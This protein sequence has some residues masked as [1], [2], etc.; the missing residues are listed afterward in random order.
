L[1]LPAV[2]AYFS[3]LR[4]FNG[5]PILATNNKLRLAIKYSLE[6]EE[7]MRVFLRSPELQLDTNHL[8]QKIRPIAIGRKNWMFCWTEVGAE[9]LCMAQSLVRTCLL[10]DVNPR[11]YLIDILQRLTLERSEDEDISDL[12][13]RLWK[14]DFAD[15][16]ILCPAQTYRNSLEIS[17]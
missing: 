6:R 9:S 7:S 8:E 15:K 17:T 11:Q 2:D 1:S 16:P 3:W 12:I 5:K 13:P 4:D 14:E 10:Q